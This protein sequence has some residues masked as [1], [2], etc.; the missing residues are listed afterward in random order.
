MIADYIVNRIDNLFTDKLFKSSK[1]ASQ[2]IQAPVVVREKFNRETIRQHLPTI[3]SKQEISRSPACRKDRSSSPISK[4]RLKDILENNRTET[5]RN[6]IK[7]D[8]SKTSISPYRKFEIEPCTSFKAKPSSEAEI[9]QSAV[10]N[11]E[12]DIIR[13]YREDRKS[14][15]RVIKADRSREKV[16]KSRI[17]G[18]PQLSHN[19]SKTEFR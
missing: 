13:Y 2:S 10:F 16:R 17:F 4:S 11:K 1:S 6:V 3:I 18:P 15:D 19:A 9:K 7:R 14:M 12:N 5:I 8:A